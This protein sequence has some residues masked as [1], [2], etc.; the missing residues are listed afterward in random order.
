[1]K[2]SANAA[3]QAHCVRKLT[4][5]TMNYPEWQ[6]FDEDA[7]PAEG[8]STNAASS[9]TDTPMVDTD[10]ASDSR[11][12]LTLKFGG[13]NKDVRMANGDMSDDE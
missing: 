7:T 8:R 13:A 5:E 12:K 11:Q 2:A 1:M 4:E 10:G 9:G 6:N 3:P